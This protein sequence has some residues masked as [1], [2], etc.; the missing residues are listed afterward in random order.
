MSTL[1]EY[2]VSN[3][4]RLA[5]CSGAENLRC[6]FLRHILTCPHMRNCVFEIGDF[7]YVVYDKMMLHMR[8]TS[9]IH[10]TAPTGLLMKALL[11]L[12]V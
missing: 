4:A 12:D 5:V 9:F 6:P 10:C 2:N 7:F 11:Y 8:Q 1:L 3:T